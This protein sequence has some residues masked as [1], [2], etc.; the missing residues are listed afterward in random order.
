M[1]AARREKSAG[2]KVAKDLALML[3]ATNL[4]RQFVCG[5]QTRVLAGLTLWYQ[6]A[7][8]HENQ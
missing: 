1:V 5:E 3:I 6:E 4:W 7:V 2:M 8:H